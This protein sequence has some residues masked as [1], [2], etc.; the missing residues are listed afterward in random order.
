MIQE[1]GISA[2]DAPTGWVTPVHIRLWFTTPDLGRP[3][4]GTFVVPISANI[5]ELIQMHLWKHFYVAMKSYLQ[6]THTRGVFR[7]TDIGQYY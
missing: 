4:E 1:M 3:L 7:G 5:I 2:T 6:G